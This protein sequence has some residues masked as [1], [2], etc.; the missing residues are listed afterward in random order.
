LSERKNT[1]DTQYRERRSTFTAQ[2][3][4][5]QLAWIKDQIRDNERIW[6]GFREVEIKMIGAHTLREVVATLVTNLPRTFTN[7]DCVTLACADPEY[8]MARIVERDENPRLLFSRRPPGPDEADTDLADKPKDAGGLLARTRSAFIP[9]APN[10]LSSLF[11]RPW[12]P[13][14]G[15]CDERLQAI[16]FPHYIHKLGS[17]ALAPLVLRGKLIGALNQGSRERTHFTRDAATDLLKHLAAV[18]SLCLDSAISHERLKLDGLT[19]PLTSVANRRFFERRLAEE[20][21]RWARH[22]GPLTCMLVDVDHFKQVNDSHGHQAGDR[23][24]RQVAYLLGQD[25]RAVDVLARY[26]GEEFVM[27]LPNT[28][29]EQGGVIA[30]RLRARVALEPITIERDQ[31]L[32]VTVSI[33]IASLDQAHGKQEVPAG[34]WLFQRA[35]AALYQAKQSGRNKVMNDSG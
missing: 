28:S 7:V 6:A 29:I 8:E 5:E 13:R 27:L 11:P 24:L 26:G 3:H 14:L 33:G 2:G 18:T 21:E 9:L 32:N 25:L 4:P 22:G 17:V 19:D 35:D 30:E 23:A 20:V 31:R 1:G 16:L 12:E 15:R 10:T 34:A